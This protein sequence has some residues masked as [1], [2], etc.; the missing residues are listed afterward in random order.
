MGGIGVWDVGEEG[1]QEN[2][3]YNV[4]PCVL[5]CSLDFL[6]NI[7]CKGLLRVLGKDYD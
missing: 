7:F 6:K 1:E 2:M 5:A 3:A 4:W